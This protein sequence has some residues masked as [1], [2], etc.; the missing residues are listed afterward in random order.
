MPGQKALT[1]GREPTTNSTYI[2]RQCQDSNVGQIGGGQVLS[3]LCH[4]C[5]PSTLT[6]QPR[7]FFKIPKSVIL[8]INNYTFVIINLMQVTNQQVMYVGHQQVYPGGQSGVVVIQPSG[9]VATVSHG[10]SMAGQQTFVI[11]P[12]VTNA[13]W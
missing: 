3:T 12:Q 4:P 11:P 10:Y 6:A 2:W 1:Q 5:S 13:L 7:S 8:Q 9:A